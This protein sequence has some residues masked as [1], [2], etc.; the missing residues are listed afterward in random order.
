MSRPFAPVIPFLRHSLFD[1][2]VGMGSRKGSIFANDF[3][4][5]VIVRTDNIVAVAAAAAAAEKKQRLEEIKSEL[6]E[7]ETR[8]RVREIAAKTTSK[9]KNKAYLDGRSRRWPQESTSAA[10]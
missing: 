4:S 6:R 8:Q 9:E 1:A 7:E 10:I 5:I 2:L 3:H